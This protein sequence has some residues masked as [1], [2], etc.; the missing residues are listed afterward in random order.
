M[1]ARIARRAM[2][3]LAC[4]AVQGLVIRS[5]TR[6]LP[7]TVLTRFVITFHRTALAANPGSHRELPLHL[8]YIQT[9]FDLTLLAPFAFGFK[10]TTGER[11]RAFGFRRLR[12]RLGLLIAR[13]LRDGRR[14]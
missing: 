10:Q 3:S 8:P 9:E 5:Q 14:W 11:R 12:R 13:R 6:L 4:T 2:M 1:A 7:Q